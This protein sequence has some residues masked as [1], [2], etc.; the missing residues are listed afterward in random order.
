LIDFAWSASSPL[1][2]NADFAK[3]LL[4]LS[5]GVSPDIQI[6]DLSEFGKRYSGIESL[7][8]VV[9]STNLRDPWSHLAVTATENVSDNRYLF[10]FDAPDHQSELLDGELASSIGFRQTHTNIMNILAGFFENAD[11]K[12]ECEKKCGNNGNCASAQLV[13]SNSSRWICVC[14]KDQNRNKRYGEYCEVGVA[15]RV[16]KGFSAMLVGIPTTIMIVM[17]IS[18]WC[19]FKK[20]REEPEIRTIA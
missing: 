10:T 11:A 2:F 13:G 18:A 9:F 5:E 19:M 6:P 17:G 16:F 14:A 7:K 20:E 15:D 1:N 12:G 4:Q 8:N 3:Y